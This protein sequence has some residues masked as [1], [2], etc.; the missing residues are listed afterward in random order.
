MRSHGFSLLLI[1]SGQGRKQGHINGPYLYLV[2]LGTPKHFSGPYF[3]N[4]YCY[5]VFSQKEVALQWQCLPPFTARDT[6][7]F[8]Q[9]PGQVV[10]YELPTILFPKVLKSI[11]LYS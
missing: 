2:K 7:D 1:T 3:S 9:G 11:I 10:L 6:D 8:D 4:Y 5:M